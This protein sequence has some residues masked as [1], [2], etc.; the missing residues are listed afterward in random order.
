MKKTGLFSKSAEKPKC[1]SDK[2]M[3]TVLRNII[4]VTITKLSMYTD[5]YLQGRSS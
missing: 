4:C 5:S 1:L 2:D 3:R